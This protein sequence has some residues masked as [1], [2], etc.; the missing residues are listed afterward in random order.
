M[1]HFQH[2]VKVYRLDAWIDGKIEGWTWVT[3]HTDQK[4]VL[5]IVVRYFEQL[6]NIP[7]IVWCVK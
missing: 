3:R 4:Y 6:L 7:S 5:C 1:A 2:F